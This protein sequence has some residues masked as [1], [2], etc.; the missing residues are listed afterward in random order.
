M[1]KKILYERFFYCE[2]SSMTLECHCL[3]FNDRKLLKSSNHLGTSTI[4]T[5][6][7]NMQFYLLYYEYSRIP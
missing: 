5:I 3:P 1:Y 7:N 6:I 4:S 2:R